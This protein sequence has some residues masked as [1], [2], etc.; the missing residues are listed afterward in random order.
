[1]TLLGV[2]WKLK[3]FLHGDRGE[4]KGKIGICVHIPAEG[5]SFGDVSSAICSISCFSNLNPDRAGLRRMQI[6]Q[7]LPETSP[8]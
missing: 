3:D 7:G 1:M 6:Q 4:K 5:T 2:I 8:Y